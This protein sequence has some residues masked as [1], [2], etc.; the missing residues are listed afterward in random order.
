MLD[1]I[2][3]MCLLDAP[4]RYHLPRIQS[5]RTPQPLPLA[6]TQAE[7][8]KVVRRWREQNQYHQETS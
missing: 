8:L 4:A 5:R 7:T 1:V 3:T 6:T 2:G